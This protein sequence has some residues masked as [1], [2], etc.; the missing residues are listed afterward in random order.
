MNKPR[1]VFCEVSTGPSRVVGPNSIRRSQV[2]LKGVQKVS[3]LFDIKKKFFQIS[4][5]AF[6][7]KNFLGKGIGVFS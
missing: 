2:V 5:R 1:F 7:N 4:K 6:R 3:I